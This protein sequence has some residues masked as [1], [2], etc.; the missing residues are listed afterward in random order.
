MCILFDGLPD[1]VH[2]SLF[3]NLVKDSCDAY[4]FY[5]KPLNPRSFR[6]LSHFSIV[7]LLARKS[8]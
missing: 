5:K 8:V 4:Y 1:R 3:L 2:S 6:L 7:L